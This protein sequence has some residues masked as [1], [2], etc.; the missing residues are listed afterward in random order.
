MVRAGPDQNYG[1]VPLTP[2]TQMQATKQ[3]DAFINYTERSK[4][5]AQAIPQALTHLVALNVE[6]NVLICI[7]CKFALKPTTLTRHLA[8]KHKTPIELRGWH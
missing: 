6:F 3:S 2:T 7:Q 4:T 5:M 8:D 1:V